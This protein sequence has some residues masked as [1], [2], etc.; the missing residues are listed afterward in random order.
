MNAE[1]RT[2]NVE[3]RMEKTAPAIRRWMLEV[4]RLPAP[5]RQGVK[6]GYVS[7]LVGPFP[8]ARRFGP[9]RANAH[10][11]RARNFTM[12]FYDVNGRYAAH[13]GMTRRSC[14]AEN[15]AAKPFYGTGVTQFIRRIS[16]ADGV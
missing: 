7:L 6:N 13:C 8:G 14:P 11:D 10:F 12:P 16:D 4:R 2:S 5:N 9:A 15:E 1:R 3:L